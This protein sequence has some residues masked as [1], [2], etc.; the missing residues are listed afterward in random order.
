MNVADCIWDELIFC[1]P[2]YI[3]RG[4]QNKKTSSSL[5]FFEVRFS[6]EIRTLRDSLEL[7]RV[8]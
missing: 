3:L 7:F 4:T 1:P 6:R 8:N 2:R 5:F